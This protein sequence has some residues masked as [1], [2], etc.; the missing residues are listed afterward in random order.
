MKVLYGVKGSDEQAGKGRWAL[1]PS[2]YDYRTAVVAA[3]S[4][5]QGCRGDA[6]I[7]QDDVLHC[8]RRL[9]TQSRPDNED[10][11]QDAAA[12]VAVDRPPC[13]IASSCHLVSTVTRILV[14]L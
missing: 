2:A 5:L 11:W 6:R 14:L 4:R 8:A 10:D 7:P 9:L 3:T 13:A 1:F 12:R